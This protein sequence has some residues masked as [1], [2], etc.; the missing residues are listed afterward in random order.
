M[1]KT[2]FGW[3]AMILPT[4]ALLGGCGAP[5]G[6]G[7]AQAS[8]N[9]DSAEQAATSDFN[10][11]ALG[12]SVP[13]DSDSCARENRVDLYTDD[14]DDDNES[15]A[16]SWDLP[17]TIRRQPRHHTHQTGTRWS[18]CKV[19]GRQFRS[20]TKYT[21]KPQFFYATLMLGSECPNGSQRHIRIVES[22]FDDNRSAITGP[23]VPNFIDGNQ[24][25][26]FFCLFGASPDKMTSFPDLGLEYAVFHDYD[27]PQP[28][29]FISKKWVYS[30]D[31]DDNLNNSFVDDAPFRAMISG[32]RNTLYELARVR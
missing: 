9:V 2:G 32:D 22:E 14:E 8:E 18:F 26:L 13:L 4:F 31:E 28:D 3:M 24:V 16:S 11:F 12:V 25:I 5:D 21:G 23:A 15:D 7:P 10:R 30:D 6:T 27:G 17:Q 29:L 20:L 1:M 19:D